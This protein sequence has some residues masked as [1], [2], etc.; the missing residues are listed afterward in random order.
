MYWEMSKRAFDR[1]KAVYEELGVGVHAVYAL[2]GGAHQMHG[3]EAL[4]F[5]DRHLNPQGASAATR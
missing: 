4:D 2:F 1:V 5:F 3:E